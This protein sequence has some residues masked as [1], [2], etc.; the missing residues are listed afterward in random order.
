MIFIIVLT[1]AH[2]IRIINKEIC[3]NVID[4]VQASYLPRWRVVGSLH[5]DVDLPSGGADR[6]AVAR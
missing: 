1:L 4:R 2:I 3:L 5:P 6:L